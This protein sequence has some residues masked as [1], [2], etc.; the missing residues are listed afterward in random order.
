MSRALI[1]MLSVIAASCSSGSSRS[2]M[3]TEPSVVSAVPIPENFIWRSAAELD[4][5]A[6]NAVSRGSEILVEGTQPFIR[7]HVG[8]DSFALRSPDLPADAPPITGVRVVYRWLPSGPAHPLNIFQA[9]AVPW[10]PQ[11]TSDRAIL[12]LE[13]DA[14]SWTAGRG[15]PINSPGLPFV[16]RYVYFTAEDSVT[17]G[18]LDIQSIELTR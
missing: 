6:H 12:V 18:V 4:S 3:F 5:W 10:K 11:Y 2:G 1:M 14:P 13:L 15:D 16:A 17:P 8:P 9:I 7:I